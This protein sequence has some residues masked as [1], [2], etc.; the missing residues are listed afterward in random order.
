LRSET[1]AD[2][3]LR[4]GQLAR[5]A[6]ISAD[7]VR[8]YERSGLLPVA[9][10]SAAGY[11]LFPQRAVV[12]LRVI[13]AAMSIGFSVAELAGIFRD[14]E[15]GT[16]PCRG[17]RRLAAAK[18]QTLESQIRELRHWR[19]E[20]RSALARWDRML[21]ATPRRGRAHLLES[22]ARVREGKHNR[23]FTPTFS[24]PRKTRKGKEQ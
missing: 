2:R 4:S 19:R 10:R 21:A 17:V 8:Y 1:T 7:S 15:S 24:L 20:L 9:P 12:R 22:L 5:L 16:A 13:R 6:G 14:R 3:P 18:L 23:H 11:R